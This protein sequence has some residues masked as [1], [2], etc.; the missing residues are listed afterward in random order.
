MATQP[1]W[2]LN[3]LD[4]NI[5]TK[6]QGDPRT[7]ANPGTFLGW[8]KQDIFH[9]VL[10]FGQADFD[11]PIG[12]LT[13]DDRAL[14][15]ARYN[16]PRHLD[17][18]NSAFSSLLAAPPPSR[19]TVIDLGCGPFTAGLAFASA[20]GPENPF[21]YYGVDTSKSMCALGRKLF[22]AAVA[23]A[24]ISPKS[25][26]WFGNDLDEAD[27]GKKVNNLTVVVA[28]YLFASPSLD[29]N[30]LVANVL[31]TLARVGDGPAAVLYTNSALEKLNT[32][33][34][35]FKDRLCSAGFSVKV[36]ETE[37]F[38]GTKNPKDLRYALFFRNGSSKINCL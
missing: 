25:T 37:T 18:L 1:L 21:R 32:K 36:E 34:P 17:E 38:Y 29:A 3:V 16:Q 28:S 30:D 13:G 4:A 11:A 23:Q 5:E 22:D 26:C 10:G 2:L 19:P 8:P 35:D 14:L 33:Y 24:G 15:Y 20:I 6:I 31:D 27:F 12:H 9:G 7:L